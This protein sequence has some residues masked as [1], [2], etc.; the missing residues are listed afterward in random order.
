MRRKKKE[1]RNNKWASMRAV[2]GGKKPSVRE[3][4][5]S[6]MEMAYSPTYPLKMGSSI[7]VFTILGV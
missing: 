5:I 2:C 7:K 3:N 6:D 1:T 4:T